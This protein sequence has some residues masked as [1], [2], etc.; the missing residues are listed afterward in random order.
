MITNSIWR[1][2]I[3]TVQ[4]DVASDD[5]CTHTVFGDRV[6][7]DAMYRHIHCVN[8]SSS[9]SQ[10]LNAAKW[11]SRLDRMSFTKDKLDLETSP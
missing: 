9:G 2:S 4:A 5:A 10:Q 11:S 6:Y 3:Y 8:I 1:W 7:D